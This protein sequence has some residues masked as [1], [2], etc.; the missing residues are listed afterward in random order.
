M[1]S[2]KAAGGVTQT[3]SLDEGGDNEAEITCFAGRA[4]IHNVSPTEERLYS[5]SST[6]S[7][8]L[9]FGYISIFWCSGVA[10]YPEIMEK[11]GIVRG[12]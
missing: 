4:H 11:I 1:V 2:V 12:L 3:S 5:Q 8:F 9:N 6:L 10:H 7:S